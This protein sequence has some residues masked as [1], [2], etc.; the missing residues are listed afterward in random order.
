MEKKKV[1]PVE[2]VLPELSYNSSCLYFYVSPPFPGHHV[3]AVFVG[4]TR[5]MFL[6]SSQLP[7]FS[8]VYNMYSHKV[9]MLISVLPDR[10]CLLPVCFAVSSPHCHSS[11]SFNSPT[12]RH[13]KNRCRNPACG[14]P[15][16]TTW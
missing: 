9:H 3:L 7:L 4:F 5:K 13:W 10:M 8:Y 16:T 12:V 11:N 14:F 15:L 6:P 1:Y 2:S